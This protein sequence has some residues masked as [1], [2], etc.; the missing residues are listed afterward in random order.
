[1]K[2][3]VV[4]LAQA[5]S[6]TTG[7]EASVAED[8]RLTLGLRGQQASWPLELGGGI[9]HALKRGALTDT[10][11]A[12]HHVTREEA[13]SLRA[14]GHLFADESGNAYLVGEGLFVQ[15]SG[16]PPRAR[17]A[18]K[19]SKAFSEA[20][21]RVTMLLLA[22]PAWA[23]LTVR[24]LAEIAGVTHG[25]AHATLR[26]LEALGYLARVEGRR[27][28]LPT[29]Q[30]ALLEEWAS[31]Y[32]RKARPKL[33]VDRY[34]AADPERLAHTEADAA[35]Y[36]WSGDDA[37]AWLLPKSNLRP[38]ERTLYTTDPPSALARSLRLV[39]DPE[40]D[41]NV[42]R[43]FWNAA[44]TVA[45]PPFPDQEATAPPAL[46][47]APWPIVYADLMA[48]GDAR[49]VNAATQLRTRALP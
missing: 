14:A 12:F 24:A 45:H 26:D 47:V 32:V 44:K 2:V 36:A 29:R 9:R 39:P 28:L 18:V 11:L 4:L 15:V 5:L 16:E 38:A 19:G 33:Y 8:G 42:Y 48:Q 22:W 3:D 6:A 20:G 25:T 27:L 10:V 37:A 31:A 41:V 35:R 7:A 1:M 23:D 13:S 49:S 30:K 34:R 17:P 21:S 40:G 46:P 43:L